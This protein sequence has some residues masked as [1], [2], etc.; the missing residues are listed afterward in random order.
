MFFYLSK[1]LHFLIA[2]FTWFILLALAAWLTKKQPRKR[3]LWISAF[4]VL[5]IFSNPFIANKAMQ[6]WEMPQVRTDSF[7][8]PYE[9]GILLGGSLR[10]FDDQ[11]GRPVYSHSVDRLLQTIALYKSGKIKKILLSGGSG[12]ITRPEERESNIILKVLE[13]TGIPKS[14]IISEN[15]SRNTYEN[16]V[17]SAALLKQFHL[18][19]KTLLITSS[20]HMRRSLACFHKAGIRPDVFPV[21]P[22]SHNGSYTPENLIIPHPGALLTWDALLH[23]WLGMLTY[24][25]AGYI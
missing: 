8:N 23:E 17:Y 4:C 22:R 19:G 16:A 18:E 9:V 6:S 5:I 1:I 10:G 15:D 24:K 21:D 12:S 3:K 13:E 25:L 2:P 7:K 14:D 11:L 20:F